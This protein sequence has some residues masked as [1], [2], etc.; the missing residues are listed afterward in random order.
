MGGFTH[1]LGTTWGR[2]PQ[3][4]AVW[5]SSCALPESCITF[6]RMPRTCSACRPWLPSDTTRRDT[7]CSRDGGSRIDPA[8]RNERVLTTRQYDGNNQGEMRRATSAPTARSGPNDT[9]TRTAGGRASRW[10]RASTVCVEEQQNP[11]FR[12][13]LC[14]G[15]GHRSPAVVAN[16]HRPTLALYRAGTRGI[17]TCPVGVR[18]DHARSRVPRTKCASMPR[19]DTGLPGRRS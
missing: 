15:D 1:Q 7:R 8:Q 14:A 2:F 3:R 4:S 16:D 19:L 11:H 9:C 5:A 17:I 10:Q 6:C 18:G 12:N 13:A